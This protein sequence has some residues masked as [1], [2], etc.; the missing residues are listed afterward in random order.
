MVSEW[1]S[2]IAVSLNVGGGVHLFKRA[3]LY[4][5]QLT[6]HKHDEKGRRAPGVRGP[7]SVSLS[8]SGN[9]VT[10]FYTHCE[11]ILFVIK[12]KGLL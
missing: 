8:H 10:R 2:V 11:C 7:S 1:Q 5:C 12:D 4:M 6:H 3:K 9:V